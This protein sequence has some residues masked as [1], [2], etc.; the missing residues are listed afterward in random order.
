M[1]VGA[2]TTDWV[3]P[4]QPTIYGAQRNYRGGSQLPRDLG[5]ELDFGI[6]ARYPIGV[7]LY[8]NGGVQG[9]VMF[10]GHA[11][12]DALGNPMHTLGLVRVMAGLSY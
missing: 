11:F 6:M 7:G 8:I 2:S 12:D 3:D 9:G 5:L 4:T 1:V 10:P